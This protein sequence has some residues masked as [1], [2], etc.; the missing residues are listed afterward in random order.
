MG[1]IPT[2]AKLADIMG[3]NLLDGISNIIKDFKLSPEDKANLQLQLTQNADV[4]A[5]HE[6]D[7]N[8]KLND[9]AGENIRAEDAA[10]DKYTERARPS[11]I[12]VGLFVIVWNYCGPMTVV[13][14]FLHLGVTTLDLPAY[15]WEAWSA[16]ALG[17]VVSRTIDK[18]MALPGDSSV[19]LPFGLGSVANKS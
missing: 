6:E 10:G 9:I 3:G 16:I 5:E 4:V 14:H 7:Y 2:P 18:T 8:A 15:F 11:V 1:I 13:N 12:W 17:Y 19:K